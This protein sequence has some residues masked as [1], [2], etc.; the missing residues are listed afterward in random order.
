MRTVDRFLN[1]WSSQRHASGEKIIDLSLALQRVETTVKALGDR[2]GHLDLRMDHVRDN[3]GFEYEDPNLTSGLKKNVTFLLDTEASM[4]TT[5]S[6]ENYGENLQLIAA[7]IHQD[8]A[9]I[10]VQSP[11]LPKRQTIQSGHLTPPPLPQ[12]SPKKDKP[13]GISVPLTTRP[14]L[15][16]TPKY[17]R[18]RLLKTPKKENSP[19]GYIEMKTV[20]LPPKKPPRLAEAPLS[21]PSLEPLLSK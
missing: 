12:K 1:P 7:E 20:L 18:P 9:E 21:S 15:L 6:D 13:V 19:S 2:I 8:P 16:K 10:V 5:F 11:E 17:A 4:D 14:R 3:M